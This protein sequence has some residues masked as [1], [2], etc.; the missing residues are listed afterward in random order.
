MK[1]LS[2]DQVDELLGA[3]ALDALT[4]EESD[5]VQ[6]HLRTCAEHRQLAGQLAPALVRLAD[7]APERQPSAQLR[8]R[9]LQAIKAEIASDVKPDEPRPRPIP[10]TSRTIRG[11]RRPAWSPAMA[12]MAAGLLLAFAGGIGLDR[13]ISRQGQPAQVAWVF[14]G[15]AHAPEAT[16]HLTYFRDRRQAVLATIGLPALSEGKVYEIWLIS[17]GA[18][19]DAGTS[20]ASGGQMVVVMNRDLSL[21]QKVAITEEPGEQPRPTGPAMVEGALTASTS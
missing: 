15:N 14:A 17:N 11:G 1:N 12:A 2:H 10:I 6:A 18:P 7:A 5:E 9:L 21:Y 4:H 16:A 20:S 8:E 13:L 3:Y 19:V